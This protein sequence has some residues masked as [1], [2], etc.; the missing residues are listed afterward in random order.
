MDGAIDT[1]TP[2]KLLNVASELDC[3]QRHTNSHTSP[4]IMQ[5]GLDLW[6]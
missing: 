2:T 6:L 1:G 3:A 5:L 4:N